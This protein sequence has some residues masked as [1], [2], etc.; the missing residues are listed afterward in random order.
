[1]TRR[2]EFIDQTGYSHFPK[3]TLGE[4]GQGIVYR[5][6]D[7][8]LAIKILRDRK[9]LEPIRDLLERGEYLEELDFLRTL[10]LP[11]NL[12]IALPMQVLQNE[13]GYVMPLLDGLIPFRTFLPFD[14]TITES[15]I[16]N[17]LKGKNIP[18][19]AAI[20]LTL[21]TETGGLR[22]R[23]IAFSKAAAILAR[24]HGG[25]FVFNDVSPN[26][27]FVSRD[28]KASEVWFIDADN[29]HFESRSGP[30][31]PFT[32]GFGAP[33]L[34][35][36]GQCGTSMSDG[37]AFAVLAFWSLVFVHPFLGA[38][39]EPGDDWAD[40]FGGQGLRDERLKAGLVPW[41]DDVDD[42]SNGSN[43]GFKRE[44]VLG[45]ELQGLF[46]Q[47]F[48]KGKEAPWK[49]P[50]AS[51]WS[52]AFARAADRTLRCGH[53]GLSWF[54]IPDWKKCPYCGESPCPEVLFMRSD[55]WPGTSAS[56]DRCWEFVHELPS[57]RSR[58]VVPRRVFY[59]FSAKNSEESVLEIIFE[60]NSM[61][62]RSLEESGF[63]LAI[64]GKN[65]RFQ[66][67]CSRFTVSEASAVNE[68]WLLVPGPEPRLI[69]CS[70]ERRAS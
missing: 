37:Y 61:T 22:K 43:K 28:G 2:M 45:S 18:R 34:V 41:I 29:I 39:V 46:Q 24:L 65:D 68:F 21:Y 35:R 63:S 20:N 8:D 1:M 12:H 17:W 5:T 26:N 42:R 49:R 69:R 33:E 40:D 15:R 23:L 59:P 60:K 19:Q 57:R 30:P 44:Q 58:I 70:L 3:S 64:P 13:A 50:D 55:R 14:S 10:P 27:I 67:I 66:P 4:G 56:T 48:G 32:E 38:T 31:G 7:P 51:E 9:T 62:L 6:E 36:Y 25:G 52:R 54:S 16:P 53:C 11:E 47:T